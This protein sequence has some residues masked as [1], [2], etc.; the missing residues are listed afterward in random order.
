M[1]RAV[2]LAL[3]SALSALPIEAAEPERPIEPIVHLNTDEV[4]ESLPP[5]LRRKEGE[6]L[7]HPDFLRIA[8]VTL[9]PSE[10]YAI[11]QTV[12]ETRRPASALVRFTLFP[13]AEYTYRLNLSWEQDWKIANWT[14]VDPHTATAAWFVCPS[15]RY[16]KSE[17]GEGRVYRTEACGFRVM[18]TGLP[19]A[20]KARRIHAVEHLWAIDEYIPR[21][22]HDQLLR[23]PEQQDEPDR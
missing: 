3:F 23:A 9:D 4:L 13:D 10:L 7:A 19:P 11:E 17:P 18:P 22:T 15:V 12:V 20:Y 8:Y 2:L 21:G 1:G 5:E 14:F 6:R 16:P